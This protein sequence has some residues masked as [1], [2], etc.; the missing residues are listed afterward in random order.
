MAIS[1]DA[2]GY[3]SLSTTLAGSARYGAE[4]GRRVVISFDS[5]VVHRFGQV[6]VLFSRYRVAATKDGVSSLE[7]GLSTEIFVRHDRRWVQ[8]SWHLDVR[9]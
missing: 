3:Q 7:Q 5:T 6:A 9:P 8:T 1:P 4:P 2:P